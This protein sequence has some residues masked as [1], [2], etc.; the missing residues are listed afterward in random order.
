[1]CPL[2]GSPPN[3]DIAQHV[4]ATFV[5]VKFRIDGLP[6]FLVH[7][8]MSLHMLLGSSSDIHFE[9]AATFMSRDPVANL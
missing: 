9:E 2:Q 3:V 1:M 8:M 6:P 4:A 7:C 5:H